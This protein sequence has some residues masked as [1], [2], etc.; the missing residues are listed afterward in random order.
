MLETVKYQNHLGEEINFSENGIYV[1]SSDLHDYAWNHTE[2]GGK[3]TSFKRD[4]ISKKI[5][6]AIACATE[7]AGIQKRND[8]VECFEKDVL[9]KQPGKIFVNGYYLK[10]YVTASS[11][12]KYLESMKTMLVSLELLSDE[13]FWVKEVEATYVRDSTT[14]ELTGIINPLDHEAN[15]RL[16]IFGSTTETTISIGGA[17]HGLGYGLEANTQLVI[18]SITKEVYILKNGKKNNAFSERYVSYISGSA[19]TMVGG[20]IKGVLVDDTFKKIPSGNSTIGRSESFQWSL[21]LYDER[22][23]PK[24]I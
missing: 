17:T 2:R 7:A 24:W 20:V 5:D 1:K 14:N 4:V 15:F 23:E 3:I 21:I 19:G 13:P 16:T 18:D 10:C 22:S 9:A 12:S 8:L 11:K 6:L